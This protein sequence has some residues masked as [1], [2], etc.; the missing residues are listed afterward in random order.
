MTQET[1]V[2]NELTIPGVVD[3]ISKIRDNDKASDAIGDDKVGVAKSLF[4]EPPEEP[5]V[6]PESNETDNGDNREHPSS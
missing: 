2:D 5:T 6:E 4:N 1:E 3:I